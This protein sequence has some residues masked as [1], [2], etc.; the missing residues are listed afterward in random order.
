MVPCRT[1]QV[2]RKA[3]T[4]TGW[5]CSTPKTTETPTMGSCPARF[6]SAAMFYQSEERFQRRGARMVC[7]G[8]VLSLDFIC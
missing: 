6:P 8:K 1:Q 3:R 4:G 7:C 5:D 2:E